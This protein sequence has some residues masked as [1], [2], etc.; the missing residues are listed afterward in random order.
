MGLVT[1]VPLKGTS[2]VDANAVGGARF[3]YAVCAVYASG[4]SSRF[5][6]TVEWEDARPGALLKEG[7]A[8][9]KGNDAKGASEA[10]RRLTREFPKSRL[11]ENAHK[12]LGALGASAQGRS[13]WGESVRRMIVIGD[14]WAGAG[15]KQEARASYLRAIEASPDGPS[16][17]EAR[18]RLA[19]L[20]E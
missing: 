15:L 6:P 5:S 13:G 17:E 10:F 12:A 9:A 7:E 20:G 2:F 14:L 11:V 16:A 18:V 4:R 8:K 19:K 3:C 1:P